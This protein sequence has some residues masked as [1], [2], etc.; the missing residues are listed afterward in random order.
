MLELAKA[1]RAGAVEWVRVPDP[2]ARRRPTRRQV[3][4]YTEFARAEGIW[5]DSGIVYVA[6][7]GDSRIQAYD[8]RKG[9]IDVIHDGLAKR[10][11]PLLRVDNT[12]SRA[13]SKFLSVT[14]PK[15][16]ESELTGVTFDPSGQRLYFAS[17]RAEGFRG[18]VYEVSG[19]FRR[20]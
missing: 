16:A 17:Q 7:T 11:A 4:G 8:T 6:T 19:P 3:S 10:S 5:F 20:A 14:G 9:R 18:A 12:R 15:H 1:G 13:V 2:L